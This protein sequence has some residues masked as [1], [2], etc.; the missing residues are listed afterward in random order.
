MPHIWKE[1]VVSWSLV[2]VPDVFREIGNSLGHCPIIISCLCLWLF[3]VYI[4]R[5]QQGATFCSGMGCG[6]T[7]SQICQKFQQCVLHFM[8]KWLILL[9]E[10]V[11]V[12]KHRQGLFKEQAIYLTKDVAEKSFYPLQMISF[13]ALWLTEIAW[14]CI[15]LLKQSFIAFG[16]GY[17]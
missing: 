8:Q 4:F 15:I 7:Y 12:S 17:V 6:K 9:K 16:K 1:I 3:S 13:C 11:G 10:G 5:S 2:M 14:K